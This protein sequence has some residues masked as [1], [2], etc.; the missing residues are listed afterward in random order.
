MEKLT[1]A[2]KAKLNGYRANLERIKDM[3]PTQ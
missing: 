2:Q 3:I 1:D